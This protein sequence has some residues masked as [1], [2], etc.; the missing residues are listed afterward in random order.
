MSFAPTSGTEQPAPK[1]RKVEKDFEYFPTIPKIHYAGQDSEDP[2]SYRFYNPNEIILGKPMKD[3][4]RFSVC[5]WHTVSI[6]LR[7]DL[8][9]S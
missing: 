3:W 4:L 1:L 9:S 5:F 8:L 6:D 2:L 7:L